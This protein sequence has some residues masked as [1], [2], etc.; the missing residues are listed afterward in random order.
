MGLPS[1]LNN[2][3]LP[4]KLDGTPLPKNLRLHRS[5]RRRRPSG[6]SRHCRFVRTLSPNLCNGLSYL[7]TCVMPVLDSMSF[8]SETLEEKVDKW[9]HTFTCSSKFFVDT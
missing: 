7:L 2:H 1:K 8:T 9:S 6:F 5:V 3:A 4:H